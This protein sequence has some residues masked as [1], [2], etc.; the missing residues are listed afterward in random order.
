M[1]GGVLPEIAQ[2]SQRTCDGQSGGSTEQ[3]AESPDG[4]HTLI[5]TVVG[6]R[7]DATYRQR[8]VDAGAAHPHPAQVVAAPRHGPSVPAP[9][10][11][12]GREVG[13]RPR[14]TVE[15]HLRAATRH[16]IL[17]RFFHEPHTRL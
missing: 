1:L 3:N 10:H 16:E 9:R 2:R 11:V 5:V 6:S 13:G 7:L 17:R 8:A 14:G 12:S 4:G 15:Y